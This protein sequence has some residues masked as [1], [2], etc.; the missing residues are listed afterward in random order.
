MGVP[1]LL[2]LPLLLLDL[3]PDQPA[4]CKHELL[5]LLLLLSMVVEPQCA[6]HCLLSTGCRARF[7]VGPRTWLPP[8]PRP[9]LLAACYQPG[10]SA[11]PH[12]PPMLPGAC[13]RP[14]YCAWHGCSGNHVGHGC[15]VS[16]AGNGCYVSHAGHGRHSPSQLDPRLP[17]LLLPPL[18]A[19]GSWGA[20]GAWAHLLLRLA[21]RAE[22]MAALQAHAQG[23]LQGHWHPALLHARPQEQYCRPPLH[24]NARASTCPGTFHGASS[25]AL[26]SARISTA[27]RL[28]GGPPAMHRLPGPAAAPPLQARTPVHPRA[29]GP[30]LARLQ[31]RPARPPLAAGLLPQ[32]PPQP[33]HAVL[34]H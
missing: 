14:G 1:L 31:P 22:P 16:H 4:P 30:P 2:L 11:V 6:T 12:C 34:Q 19:V 17:L 33:R 28:L 24:C 9:L 21:A 5:L 18:L 10:Q 25:L 29:C 15:G 32:P 26:R 23:H 27:A 20:W 8:L 13:L 7:L 3:G